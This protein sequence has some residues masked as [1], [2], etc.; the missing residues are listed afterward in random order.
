MTSWNQYNDSFQS[1][2][3][4][5]SCFLSQSCPT[6]RLSTSLQQIPSRLN[7]SSERSSSSKCSVSSQSHQQSNTHFPKPIFS[8]SI[9]IFMALK[10]SKTGSLPVS[11][12]YSFMTEHFPYFKIAPDGWKNSVRHNLS[13]N[14]C[15]VKVENKNG[16]SSRKGCL[17]A[18]NVAKVE[19]MQ[20]ELHKWRR[21]DP[22]A[23][24]RSMAWPECFDRLLGDK[25]DKLRFLPSYTSPALS[26][27]A[28]VHSTT[29]S[30]CTPVQLQPPCE[31]IQHPPFSHIQPQECFYLPPVAAHSSS[32]F[33]LCSPCEQPTAT[34]SMNSPLA[35]KVP[36][37]FN[38]ALQAD[39]S[40]GP[41][42]MQDFL[43][44]GDPSYDIDT[45]NPSLTDLQMQDSY[46]EEFKQDSHTSDPQMSTATTSSSSALQGV[47]T[48][49]LLFTAPPVGRRKAACE[50]ANVDPG[51]GREQHGYF[52]R[53]YPL[54]YSG[55]ESLAGCL[56]SRTTSVSL[57]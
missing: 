53:L 16:N 34:G 36:L 28:S 54:V 17:W 50:E 1:S 18:L 29:I 12:I 2:Y 25:P 57:M 6:D 37:V 52:D 8:Y 24:R 9:L 27:R 15:F 4:D 46:W 41:R 47:Q 3:S 7:S 10:N 26:T 14:K 35:G 48:C 5:P 32:S 56:T 42:S 38:A 23:I 43:L 49:S 13:L 31:S 33:A 40:L 39:Y 20:D 30:S 51:Q 22:V 21:K 45:L 55:V 44:E 19:K 11:E